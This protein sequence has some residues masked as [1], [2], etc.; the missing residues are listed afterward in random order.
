MDNNNF[1]K[2]SFSNNSYFNKDKIQKSTI[3]IPTAINSNFHELISA[4][5]QLRQQQAV[6]R[7]KLEND[8][9]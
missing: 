7:K 9:K 4:Y 5:F 1:Q 3:C 6:E 8:S 2:S